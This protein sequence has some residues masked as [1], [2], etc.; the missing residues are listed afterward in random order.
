MFRSPDALLTFRVLPATKT[1]SSG[2]DAPS[3]TLPR[4]PSVAVGVRIVAPLVELILPPTKRN[5]PFVTDTTISPV[6]R[7]GS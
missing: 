7:S 1:M 5:S 6:E 3:T 4:M 2:S